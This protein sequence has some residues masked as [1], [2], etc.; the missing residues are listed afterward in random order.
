MI[1]L[2]EA[3]AISVDLVLSKAKHPDY[4]HVVTLSEELYRPL[5]TGKGIEK[6]MRRF[7]SHEA[8]DA[9][10]QRVKITQHTTPSTWSTLLNPIKKLE[11]V[12]PVVDRMEW[13]PENAQAEEKVA[14][15]LKKFRG[16]KTVDHYISGLTELSELDP[17]AFELIVFDPFDPKFEVPQ[18]YAVSVSSRDA[19]NFEY[20]NDQLRFLWVHRDI[21]YIAISNDGTGKPVMKDGHRFVLYVANHHIAFEQVR[22]EFAGFL[23]KGELGTP[24]GQLIDGSAVTFGSDTDYFLRVSE[25][26]AYR[27]TFYDQQSGQVPAFRLGSVKDPRTD[28][29]TCV[30]TIHPAMDWMLKMVKYVSEMDLTVCLHVFPKKWQ[31]APR[32]TGESCN[33]GKM[34]DGK[35]CG[36]CKGTGRTPIIGSAQEVNT[37]AMPDDPKDMFDLTKMV[38]YE[39][40]DIAVI[41]ELRE[42]NKE[43]REMAIRAVYAGDMFT[44]DQVNVTATAKAQEL[45]SAYSA[46]R[47]RIRWREEVKPTIVHVTANYLDSGTGLTCTTI[48]PQNL[49]YETEGD[50][51]ALM[52]ESAPVAGRAF[53]ASKAIDLIHRAY[54][55]DPTALKRALA[56]ERL[57]PFSGMAPGEVLQLISGGQALEASAMMWTEADTIWDIAESEHKG[58]VDLYDL[59]PD[60]IRDKVHAIRDRLIAE[61]KAGAQKAVQNMQLG[62][63]PGAD[64]D[65]QNE[66]AENI[67]A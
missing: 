42:Q 66:D 1:E 25:Q 62:M 65:A 35:T 27:V 13:E 44:K 24:D 49:R 20:F 2:K 31:Y 55:D 19:W 15:M 57:N 22:G 40:T 51:V 16:N 54:T 4:L 7:D 33:G 39:P 36:V 56:Q 26:E 43:I 41:Q 58:D 5:A 53:M 18:P 30:N 61:K 50:V 14:A 34:P 64:P 28:G 52:K 38:F 63:D 10:E 12:R 37:L 32:C 60:K 8:K 6:L 67:A 17:N 47:P 46:L 48:M 29:R 21:K 59:A 9:F 3:T 45:D 23:R 11:S